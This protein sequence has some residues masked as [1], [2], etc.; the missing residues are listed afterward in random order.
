MK[1]R[2]KEG[3]VEGRKEERK[4]GTMKKIERERNNKVKKRM[5]KGKTKNTEEE[6]KKETGKRQG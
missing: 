6:K 5:T 3:K 4:H 2:G 1:K